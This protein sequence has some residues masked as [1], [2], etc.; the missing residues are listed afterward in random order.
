[1]YRAAV[2][3]MPEDEEMIAAI[4]DHFFFTPVKAP[5]ISSCDLA[6]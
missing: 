1:M 5:A 4:S 6:P 2:P 3:V